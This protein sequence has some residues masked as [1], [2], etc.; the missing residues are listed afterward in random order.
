MTRLAS[1]RLAFGGI[2]DSRIDTGQCNDMPLGEA[3]ND[4][5]RRITA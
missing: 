3:G 2:G 1:A 5:R 4:T